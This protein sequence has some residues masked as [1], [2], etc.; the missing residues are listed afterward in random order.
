MAPAAAAVVACAGGKE[1]SASATLPPPPPAPRHALPID[2]FE[3]DIVAA[4]RDNPVTV[5]IG[6]TGSGKTTQISQFLLRNGFADGAKGGRIAVTQPRRVA[7]VTVARRVAWEL[8]SDVGDVVGYAVRFEERTS[9]RTKIK[10]LTDGCLLRECLRDPDLLSY[11]VIVLDEAHERSLNTDIL[12][13]LLK[14]L[15]K[16]RPS[17]R[18]VITSATLE[19]D[20]FA[21]FFGDCPVLRVPGRLYEVEIV[22]AEERPVSYVEAAVQTI[23]D[24]HVGSP[25][26]DILC[27]LT[28]QEEIEK[29]CH[30]I[31]DRIANMEERAC[32]DIMA[33]VFA[34]PPEHCRRAIIATNIAETSLTVDGV[35]YVVDPGMVK[36]KDHDPRRGMDR[37]SITSISRCYRLYP[38]DVY[39]HELPA[40]TVPE[41]QRTTLEGVV[42]Y[43]KTLGISD[44]LSFEFLDAPE[45]SAL[46]EALKHLYALDAIDED[47][48]VTH[49]GEKMAELPLE[50]PL[51][52]AMI[53][54]CTLDCVEDAITIAAMLSTESV[55]MGSQG[56]R[57][58]DRRGGG[59]RG[60]NND[61][62]R[63]QQDRRDPELP[64]GSGLGDHIQLLQVYHAWE[65]AGFDNEW[66]RRMRLQTRSMRFAVNVRRQL[67]QV[68]GTYKDKDERDRERDE[69]DER[70]ERGRG[71]KRDREG[72]VGGNNKDV[73]YSAVRRALCV[74]FASRLA[75]RLPR[76]NGYK[77]VS[78]S[79]VLVQVHPSSAELAADE[80]GL[81][82][83]WVL[84]QELVC[85]V[86]GK[87]VEPLL[88]KMHGVDVDRLS[89]GAS[90]RKRA[91]AASLT[92]PP[93]ADGSTRVASSQ[94]PAAQAKSADR[95]AA[96]RERFLQRR[97]EK[98]VV[99]KPA[100][101]K[102]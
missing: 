71:R 93:L 94:P 4:I 21:R 26:G 46:E 36:L 89:G 32:G 11:S 14:P 29:A 53:E 37:L 95:A 5:I 23:V 81:M 49:V 42:L 13:G 41:I 34:P 66:C 64:T 50:P 98:K 85:V 3:Q 87:W 96:A 67:E 102:K 27:F 76:H 63:Q 43:L 54:A 74:G 51:A 86:E 33:R 62:F 16:L 44:V 92:E 48:N 79:P 31:T 75:H 65:R 61:N 28:G 7:A 2:A 57:G 25:E 101:K 80:D 83:E 10:Y 73:R 45:A 12:F 17:L 100:G 72:R 55:F 82:P 68:V 60:A 99:E 6:E 20:K 30:S 97:A 56:R 84:Y 70:G 38:Q 24:I 52:R 77:T 9:S 47:G 90:R 8:G 91:V 19:C 1:E 39:D 40:A 59:E 88:R 22:Y 58:G 78:D 35:V 18:L 15:L 69:R